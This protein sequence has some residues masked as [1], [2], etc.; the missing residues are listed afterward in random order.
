MNENRSDG[1]SCVDPTEI[2][3][4]STIVPDSPEQRLSVTRERLMKIE[5][6][7]VRAALNEASNII[8]K[9]I[10]ADKLDILFYEPAI[11]S[12]VLMSACLTPLAKRQKTLGMD[13][14]PLANGGL[15]ACIYLSEES[16]MTGHADQ[17]PEVLR[18]IKGALGIRS[19]I[20][21]PL[22]VAGE[23]RGVVRVDSQKVDA[24]TESDL[25]FMEQIAGWVGIVIYKVELMQKVHKETDK[26]AKHA[27][28]EELATIIALE[29]DNYL[30]V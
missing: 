26:D 13:R 6:L 28:I 1:E 25:H 8:S 10:H 5:G 23:L 12:L 24:F 29:F 19:V 21:V 17:D 9:S 30:S 14:F 15:S 2:D 11:D 27:A 16:Y 20:G 4:G 18:G 3:T 22:Y 7:D